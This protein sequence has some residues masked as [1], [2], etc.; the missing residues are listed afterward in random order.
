MIRRFTPA[1]RSP[2]RGRSAPPA[3]PARTGTAAPLSRMERGAGG[4]GWSGC[5]SNGVAAVLSV[6]PAKAGIPSIPP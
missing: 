1:P 5:R 2:E 4:A 6:I 3:G